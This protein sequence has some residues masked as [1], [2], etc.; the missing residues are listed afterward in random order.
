M[1]ADCS[2]V[3]A[4]E[5]EIINDIKKEHI[6]LPAG[7]EIIR[8]GDQSPELY[9]LDSG[10]A[11]RYKMLLD[12]R[13]QILN[14]LFPGDLLGVQA[15]MFDAA[16]R[17][18]SVDRC[19]TVL[20]PRREIWALFGEMPGLAFR[21]HLARRARREHRRRKPRQ[22]WPAY[23]GGARSG[24]DHHALQAR[25][26]VG[27]RQ[28]HFEFPL[29]QQHIADALGLSLVHT[30]KTLAQ[31]RRMGMFP[32]YEW[33]VD[34]GQSARPRAHRSIFRKGNPAAAPDLIAAKKARAK[35]RA[36]VAQGSQSYC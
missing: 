16:L 34:L 30:N 17:H 21:R 12:G 3:T 33:N 27:S 31:L 2:S 29:T 4:E 9:T 25:Q 28:R 26:A 1:P 24:A 13:R 7:G 20:L 35:A 19:A 32:Q 22:R 8:A 18:R 14:F 6:K 5:L 23:C 15:A 36:F 11:F 10:S